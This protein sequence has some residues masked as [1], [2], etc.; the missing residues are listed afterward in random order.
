M[1]EYGS[2]ISRDLQREPGTRTDDSIP[3]VDET[4]YACHSRDATGCE[5]KYVAEVVERDGTTS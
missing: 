1:D 4:C 3:F 5:W 2:A